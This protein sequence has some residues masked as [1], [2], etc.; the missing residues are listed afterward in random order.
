MKEEGKNTATERER[1]QK[2]EDDEK[3]GHEDGTWQ[4]HW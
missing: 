2:D 3:E 4:R 1:K